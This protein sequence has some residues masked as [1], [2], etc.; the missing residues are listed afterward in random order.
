MAFPS[1]HTCAAAYPFHEK[2]FSG[3]IPTTATRVANL[4]PRCAFFEDDSIELYNLQQDPGETY[5]LSKEDPK[6]A[7]YLRGLLHAWQ[8]QVKAQHP[9]PNPNYIPWR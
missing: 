6:Q 8:A 1:C 2:Q 4:A 5:D 9:A 3:I 7:D